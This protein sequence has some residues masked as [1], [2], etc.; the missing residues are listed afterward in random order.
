MDAIVIALIAGLQCLWRM[1]L[2]FCRQR[3]RIP[4][5][6]DQMALHRAE[7]ERKRESENMRGKKWNTEIKFWRAYCQLG[8]NHSA[9]PPWKGL[10]IRECGRGSCQRSCG[11]EVVR[12]ISMLIPPWEVVGKFSPN[13]VFIPHSCHGCPLHR[14]RHFSGWREQSQQWGSNGGVNF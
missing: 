1:L 13:A 8:E 9:P 2:M 4:C 6:L 12:C 14:S 5:V 3:Y 10:T 7:S 11:S